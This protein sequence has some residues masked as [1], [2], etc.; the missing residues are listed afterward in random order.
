M[1][2]DGSNKYEINFKPT[3]RLSRSPKKLKIME[4]IPQISAVPM[5]K[6]DGSLGLNKNE[7]SPEIMGSNY[8]TNNAGRPKP[9]SLY[10]KIYLKGQSNFGTSRHNMPTDIHVPRSIDLSP[11]KPRICKY[12]S[13]QIS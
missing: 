9:E 7:Y 10:R 1:K 5:F 12:L 13:F 8:K 4:S 6:L 2:T 3:A 11:T